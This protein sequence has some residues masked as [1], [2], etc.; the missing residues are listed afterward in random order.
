MKNPIETYFDFAE[1]V[2]GIKQVVGINQT[3]LAG[4]EASSNLPEVFLLIAVQDYKTYSPSDLELLNKMV[5]AMKLADGQ[6]F[7]TDLSEIN[8][9]HFKYLIRFVDVESEGKNQT[10]ISTFSPKKL[11]QNPELK[12]KAWNDMQWLLQKMN[13]N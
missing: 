1:N 3:N 11:N 12:K 8:N 2:L 6:C 7:I 10:S 5:A 4:S 13:Q 9:Y